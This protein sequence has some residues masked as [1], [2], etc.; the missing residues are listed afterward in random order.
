MYTESYLLACRTIY[1]VEDGHTFDHLEGVELDFSVS[2]QTG[3][4]TLSRTFNISVQF[5]GSF[6]QTPFFPNRASSS[7]S[8]RKHPWRSSISSGRFDCRL[9]ISLSLTRGPSSFGKMLRTWM[10][11]FCGIYRMVNSFLLVDMYTPLK[12]LQLRATHQTTHDTPGPVPRLLIRIR[13]QTRKPQT[14]SYSSQTEAALNRLRIGMCSTRPAHCCS[15][16]LQQR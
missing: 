14:P 3:R 8:S 10:Y 16:L 1:H 9:R 5:L 2:S 6:R 12:Y 7:P 4:G 11:P 13:G 15:P